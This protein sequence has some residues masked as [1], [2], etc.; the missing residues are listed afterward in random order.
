MNFVGCVAGDTDQMRLGLRF[1]CMEY[2]TPDARIVYFFSGGDGK[3]ADPIK[4]IS[5]EDG[6]CAKSKV[7]KKGIKMKKK[8]YAEIAA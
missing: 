6:L 1:A 5:T 3:W 2:G 4:T 8:Y 7:W